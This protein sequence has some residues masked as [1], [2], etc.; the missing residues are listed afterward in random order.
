MIHGFY[1]T[2]KLI[3]AAFLMRGVS[4]RIEISKGVPCVYEGHLK[5]PK[6]WY[7]FIANISVINTAR[8]TFEFV[9][10][11][12]VCCQSILFYSEDQMNII[13]SRMNCW[14]KQNL[15]RP[16]EDQLLHLTPRFVWSGCQMVNFGGISNYVCE[17]GRSLVADQMNG[18][19]AWFVAVSNCESLYGLNLY[20]RILIYGQIGECKPERFL[21]QHQSLIE[22]SIAIARPVS[23]Q[24]Y[25]GE[26]CTVRGEL[27]T[28]ESWY[29]FITNVSLRAGGGFEFKFSYPYK[30]QKQNVILYNDKDVDE[31]NEGHDCW[32]KEGIIRSRFTREQ[33]LDLS[34]HSSWN[35]C[36]L[37]NISNDKLDYLICKGSR[38][39]SEAKHLF[40]AVSNCKSTEGLFLN[41]EIRFFGFV[42]D[43][44]SGNCKEGEPSVV[45]LA[46][47]V[48]VL[49]KY[50][51]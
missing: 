41:Y 42:G 2:L 50:I 28:T 48:L 40:F 13:N 36:L 16:E 37:K 1:V 39:Y 4:E 24:S 49:S 17:G 7:G 5:S 46:L 47:S 25:S 23:E 43:T 11:S 15:L 26:S 3:S 29:G 27:N 35:G 33:M 44:C 32:Q 38:R 51:Q 18:R 30:V 6:N 10:P 31:I 21:S 9:F 20:Y 34:L 45:I 12:T 19:Q 22:S 14:Q 8:M